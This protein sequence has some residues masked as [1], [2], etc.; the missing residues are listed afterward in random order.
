MGEIV[1]AIRQWFTLHLF[2]T[3][4]RVLFM[5]RLREGSGLSQAR[6]VSTAL[7]SSSLSLL[8][9]VLKE[10]PCWL[11]DIC[12]ASNIHRMKERTHSLLSPPSGRPAIPPATR[13]KKTFQYLSL[14][15]RS[16]NY[17]ERS[18][19]A[20]RCKIRCNKQLKASNPLNNLRNLSILTTCD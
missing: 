1:Q 8:F 6:Y 10:N 11:M 18:L 2:A 9:F 3:I 19:E 13:N 7:S 4:L 16:H 15:T 12:I 14:K 20:C 5:D 17:S